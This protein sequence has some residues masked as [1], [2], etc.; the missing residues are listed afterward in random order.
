MFLKPFL[1]E[2]KIVLFKLIFFLNYSANFNF[3]V[4][5]SLDSDDIMYGVPFELNLPNLTLLQSL[6]HV[7]MVVIIKRFERVLR[8]LL[9]LIQLYFYVVLRLI[10]LHF[11]F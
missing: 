2:I 8:Y 7:K 3:Y 11:N 6:P 10:V 5:Q 4:R 1:N 9:V